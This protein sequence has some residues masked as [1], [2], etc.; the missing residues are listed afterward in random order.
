MRWQVLISAFWDTSCPTLSEWNSILPGA[1][2]MSHKQ[3]FY[4]TFLGLLLFLGLSFYTESLRFNDD[5]CQRQAIGGGVA[6][7]IDQT[8]PYLSI[9][10]GKADEL[11]LRLAHQMP[12]GE[13]ISL[14]DLSRKDLS[15]IFSR[16][17]P[18][19]SVWFKIAVGHKKARQTQELFDK[20][21][22]EA[23]AL[24]ST[25]KSSDMSP[26]LEALKL[27]QE[28]KRYIRKGGRVYLVSDLLENSELGN[29]YSGPSPQLTTQG[30]VIVEDMKRNK[31]SFGIC[32]IETGSTKLRTIEAKR[33]FQILFEQQGKI[34]KFNCPDYQE[35]SSTHS[36]ARR[37]K[38]LKVLRTAGNP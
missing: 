16:C 38:L 7:I 10:K 8:E 17:V 11:A 5:G 3:R 31:V 23:L 21:L 20:Q 35:L 2:H 26:I 34:A 29:F 36:L 22:I 13:R 33:F 18:N 12:R 4:L 24:I 25:S 30:H 32:P 14:F 6:I 28:D 1:I 19:S 27:V 15:P 9:S 37:T